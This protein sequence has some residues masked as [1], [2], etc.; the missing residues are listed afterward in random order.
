MK[1]LEKD[2]IVKD[3]HAYKFIWTPVIGKKCIW[4]LKSRTNTMN[5]SQQTIV[6]T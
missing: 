6:A 1:E 2:G 3:H 5:T 4:V